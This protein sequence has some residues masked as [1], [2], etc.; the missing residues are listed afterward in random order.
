MPGTPQP[1]CFNHNV[2]RHIH[3]HGGRAT[4]QRHLGLQ[5][6]CWAPPSF[7]LLLSA[8]GIT[9]SNTPSS[10][11]QELWSGRGAH[12]PRGGLGA[13]LDRGS[14]CGSRAFAGSAAPS[15]LYHP[16]WT[17]L[18]RRLQLDAAWHLRSRSAHGVRQ[19][20]DPLEGHW[21]GIPGGS[22]QRSRRAGR[23]GWRGLALSQKWWTSPL[24][25]IR[26]SQLMADLRPLWMS[27]NPESEREPPGASAGKGL[28]GAGPCTPNRVSPPHP[29]CDPS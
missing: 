16:S 1:S 17:E 13:F 10:A 25:H 19:R 15:L 3:S 8:F 23:G 9:P 2:C 24:S 4:H 5:A 7:L 11:A 12:L 29:R 21:R 22:R 18:V 26:A 28:W 14:W 27:C 6:P 20:R